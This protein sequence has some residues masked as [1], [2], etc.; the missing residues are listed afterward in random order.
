MRVAPHLHQKTDEG[1]GS[2]G[3]SP[4]FLREDFFKRSTAIVET[5]ML[6]AEP[7]VP[8]PTWRQA[9]AQKARA[10]FN[11][12]RNHP[13]RNIIASGFT[14]GLIVLII[15]GKLIVGGIA[16]FTPQTNYVP[17]Y[18]LVNDSISQHGAIIINVPK[19]VGKAGA[20]A[21]VTFEPAIEGEWVDSQID[22]A[23]VFNRPMVP[24]TTLNE[25]E[26]KDIHVT[27]TPA[28]PGKFKWI[29]TRTL[30]FIPKA[31]LWGS[32][33]YK[34]EVEDG[35]VSMDGLAVPKLTH[36][37]TTKALRLDHKTGDTIR[38][39]D[40]IQFYF[41]QPVDL[42]RTR[43]A[44]RVTNNTE[45]RAIPFDAVYGTRQ[46]WDDVSNKMVEVRDPSSIS[47]TPQTSANGHTRAWEFSSSYSV[48]IDKVYP[49]GGDII[50]DSKGFGSAIST[51]VTTTS[52]LEDVQVQSERTYLASQ[53]L[54]DPSG[55]VTL[56]F[57]EDIDKGKSDISV[58]GLKKLEYG[59]RCAE[60]EDDASG[61]ECKKVDDHSKLIFTFN[62][63]AF[64]RGEK[65]SLTLEKLVNDAGY[66]VNR[67][68]IIVDLTV[69][70]ALK[71][72]RTQPESG[73]GTASISQLVVCTNSPQAG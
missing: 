2:R 72:L 58:K 64:A 71:V 33:H 47:I 61:E 27:I 41:N 60:T 25:L 69:Y 4:R 11:I 26:S 17:I 18:T 37:F 36:D 45:N 29:T 10:Y 23:I 30:Q 38:Y 52:A 22:D 34:V 68:P 1:A 20:A 31:A 16:F 44:I 28:T 6:P 15:A 70:P 5:S 42:E 65:V 7:L 67:D 55:T 3:F 56:S 53:S 48:T 35:F 12:F 57:Y 63:N 21:R 62:P 8:G 54:F 49:V 51:I 13:R 46:V 19:G 43:G 73:A 14:G 9:L 66:R 50:L 24:L 39:S 40:P 32:A 59:K